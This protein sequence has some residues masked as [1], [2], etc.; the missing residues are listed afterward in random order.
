[1]Q[2]TLQEH[3]LHLEYRIQ[4]LRDMLTASR[5]PEDTTRIDSELQ[6]AILALRLYCEAFDAEQ[7]VRL[8]RI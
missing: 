4:E 5:D 2:N 6:T 3:I 7:K 8:R 1:M